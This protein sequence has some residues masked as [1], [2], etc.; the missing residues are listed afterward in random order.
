L[1]SADST[2]LP[3]IGL[4]ADIGGEARPKSITPRRRYARVSFFSY[5]GAQP[6]VEAHAMPKRHNRRRD[7]YP[8][9]I[10]SCF[11][12]WRL[13]AFLWRKRDAEIKEKKA[14]RKPQRSERGRAGVVA[15]YTRG[16][17]RT[18]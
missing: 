9:P 12:R 2:T 13:L 18:W 10:A 1:G 4:D 11:P 8:S 16:G 5:R 6:S 14:R 15:K 3:P 7:G 17:L